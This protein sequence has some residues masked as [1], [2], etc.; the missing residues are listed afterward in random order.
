M[1]AKLSSKSFCFE[2]YNVN[3]GVK[4]QYIN[5]WWISSECMH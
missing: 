5:I 3:F 2:K 4:K 1:N